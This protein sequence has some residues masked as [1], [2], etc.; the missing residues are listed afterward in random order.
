MMKIFK[1][2]LFAVLFLNLYSET[3]V[4]AKPVPPGSGEGDVPANILFLIDSSASMSRRISNRDA[5]FGVTGVAYDT[6]NDILAGQQRHLGVVKF[7]DDGKRNREFG[8]N[9]ARWTGQFNDTCEAG[10][11]FGS[12]GGTGYSS[13][14]T[15]TRTRTGSKVRVVANMS[16]DDG[17]ISNE[18][19]I[20]F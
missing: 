4:H 3:Q 19:I 10:L 13:I 7:D 1:Y 11:S 12:S 14:I 6:N 9:A 5:V 20:F 17:T 16:T 8:N 2:F 18:D 15:D